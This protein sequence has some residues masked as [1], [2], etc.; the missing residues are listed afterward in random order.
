MAQFTG[1]GVSIQEADLADAYRSGKTFKVLAEEIGKS[2]KFVKLRLRRAGVVFRSRGKPKGS[3]QNNPNLTCWRCKQTKP[4]EEFGKDV[5]RDSGYSGTCKNCQSPYRNER[6]TLRS[7]GLT[8]AEIEQLKQAQSGRCQLCNRERPLVVD[9]KHGTKKVRG[10][11]CNP[12]N[13]GLGSFQ[14]NP[15]LLRLAADYLEDATKRGS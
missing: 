7:Y 2:V 13:L 1:F 4:R 3:W 15:A 8:L 10:I 12:C 11:L 9:H 5:Y 14:D 6:R